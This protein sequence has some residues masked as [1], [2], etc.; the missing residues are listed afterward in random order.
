MFE[1]TSWPQS[2][3]ISVLSGLLTAECPAKLVEGRSA[4][5]DGDRHTLHLDLVCF[6]YL[7]LWYYRLLWAAW[8]KV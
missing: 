8:H 1:F 2:Y 3:I 6:S 7:I 4:E 5:Q